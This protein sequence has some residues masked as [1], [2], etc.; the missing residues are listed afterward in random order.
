MVKTFHNIRDLCGAG[1][2]TQPGSF[3]L[4]KLQCSL[5]ISNAEH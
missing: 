1:Q 4:D 3:R 5:N 2:V